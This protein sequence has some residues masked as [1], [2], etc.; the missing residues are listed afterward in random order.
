MFNHLKI[1]SRL[2]LGF[3]LVLALLCSLAGLAAWQMHRLADAADFYAVNL[4]PS[5]DVETQVAVRLGD[6]RRWEYRHVLAN[7]D[8]EMDEIEVKMAGYRKETTAL[9]DRYAKDLISDDEDRQCLESVRKTL[10]VYLGVF[11]NK[12]RPISRQTTS[13]PAK[14]ADAT[15]V[16]KGESL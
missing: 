7:T 10:A 1:G 11:D 6:M 16:M 9:L 5:F 3:G 4:V 2:T 14:Q 15:Q 12:V 8:A 13:D